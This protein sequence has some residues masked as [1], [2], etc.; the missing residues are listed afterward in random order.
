M[1]QDREIEAPEAVDLL[2][3]GVGLADAAGV[4]AEAV[5]LSAVNRPA[6][7]A[8]YGARKPATPATETRASIVSGSPL[9]GPTFSRMSLK[10]RNSLLPIRRR[11]AR[12]VEV[13][14]RV[15]G[16]LVAAR[17]Q[18]VDIV[19]APAHIRRAAEIDA[20]RAA[21][22]ARTF[23]DVAIGVGDEIDAADEEREVEAF[24]VLVHL[25][26]EVGELLPAFELG[27]IVE[28][29][30]RRIAA[31][32]RR[33]PDA[34]AANRPGPRGGQDLRQSREEPPAACTRVDLLREA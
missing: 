23:V 29:H 13:A 4:V 19:D 2:R 33:P 18:R 11:P 22:L 27:A 34:G 10:A 20:R 21:P 17:V 5:A 25:G 12:A 24:A 31:D 14:D 1:R 6:L 7:L 28:R 32:A 8:R 16:D 9:L 30:E 3:P 26:G 15:R